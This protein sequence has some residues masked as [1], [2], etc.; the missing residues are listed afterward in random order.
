MKLIETIE[1]CE[2]FVLDEIE[3]YNFDIEWNQRNIGDTEENKQRI[4]K[5]NEEKNELLEVLN[6]LKFIKFESNIQELDDV[7]E[8][9]NETN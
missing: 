8:K 7:I 4:Q 3:C 2:K 1:R 5:W 6:N 9:E